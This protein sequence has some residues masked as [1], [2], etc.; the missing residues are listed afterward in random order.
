MKSNILFLFSLFTLY[1]SAQEVQLHYDFSEDR[2]YLTGTFEIFKPDKTGSTFFFTDFNFDRKDGANLAYFEIARKFNIKNEK[3]EGL[4]FHIEYNDGFLMTNDKSTSPETAIGF[5]INRAFLTGFG[6]PIKI[7]NFT[8]NTSY[9]YKNTEDSHGI[10][11]QFTAVFFQNIFNNKVTIRGF[12]DFWSQDIDLEDSNSKKHMILLTEPQVM[13]NFNPKFS[14]GSEIEIS[15]NFVS[16][17]EFK[18]YPTIMAKW[19]L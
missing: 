4:N 7:G 13:Y 12:L 14:I 11:G 15:N 3:I 16:S 8:L 1:T 19:S 18:V 10:D 17:N 6:F 2:N 9:L 5:A